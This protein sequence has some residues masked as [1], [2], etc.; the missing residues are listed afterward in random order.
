MFKFILA[1]R[2]QDPM[3]PQVATSLIYNNSRLR[4]LYQL[5]IKQVKNDRSVLRKTAPW[6]RTKQ[7]AEHKKSAVVEFTQKAFYLAQVR[8]PINS[9]A[10]ADYASYELQ[11]KLHMFFEVEYQK[12]CVL[13]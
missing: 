3:L 11:K 5:F 10:Q 2:F 9:G 13:D 8:N 7:F 12:R 1:R 4:K 6:N